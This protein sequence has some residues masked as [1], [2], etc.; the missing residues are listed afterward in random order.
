MLAILA[1]GGMTAASIWIMGPFIPAII[2]ATTLVIAT[3][4]VMLSVQRHTGGRRGIAVVVMTVALLLVL[5]LP[6]WLAIS[7][8]IANLD[9]ISGWVQTLLSLQVPAPPDWLV[10]VPLVGTQAA[11]AW[12][13]VTSA[14]VQE[15]AP[16][17]L[18]YTGELTHWLVSA[19]GGLGATFLQF[20]LVVAIAAIIYANGERAAEVT[21]RFGRRLGGDRGEATVHLAGQAIRGVALGVVVT[22][23]AQS[24]VAGIGLAVVGVPFASLLTALMFVLCLA[25]LGPGLIMIPAV[26][27]MYYMHGAVWGT[28]LLV[29][30]LAAMTMDGFLRPFLIRRGADLSL[31]LIFAGVIGGLITMGLLGI[32]IGPTVLAISVTL[33]NAWMDEPIESAE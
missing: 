9:V 6:L 18:P 12:A 2:W 20:L 28:V 14:G 11:Q 32:F 3:W 7:T 10:H 8:I 22:A 4:P 15:L 1:I 17:L 5:I 30:G 13:N 24:L 29:I 21:L 26:V 19:V 16:R 27:W 31:L 25:Q 33:L 23:V